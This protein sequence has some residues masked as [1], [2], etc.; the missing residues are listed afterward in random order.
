MPYSPAKSLPRSAT[1]CVGR[2]CAH[3]RH[4]LFF[5]FLFFLFFRPRGGGGPGTLK[6]RIRKGMLSY[7][8]SFAACSTCRRSESGEWPSPVFPH[9]WHTVDIN[10]V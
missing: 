3:S 9:L 10:P 8:G 5:F 1:L 7:A 4:I 2:D 6:V